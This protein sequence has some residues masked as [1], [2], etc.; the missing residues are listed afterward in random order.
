[1]APPMAHAGGTPVPPVKLLGTGTLSQ[2]S[3]TSRSSLFQGR[4]V[5]AELP[6]TRKIGSEQLESM[7]GRLYKPEK[8][9]AKTEAECRH[10]W[11]H[12][13][14]G[15]EAEEDPHLRGWWYR[16]QHGGRSPSPSRARTAPLRP[17]ALLPAPVSGSAVAASIL[18]THDAGEGSAGMSAAALGELVLSFADWAGLVACAGTSR[19][20]RHEACRV[21]RRQLQEQ[22]HAAAPK[23]RQVLR[24]A[25]RLAAAAGRGQR[26]RQDQLVTIGVSPKAPAASRSGGSRAGSQRGKP[27]PAVVRGDL[28]ALRV[29]I[30]PPLHFQAM[31]YRLRIDVASYDLRWVPSSTPEKLRSM[32]AAGQLR[33][34]NDLPVEPAEV[35]EWKERRDSRLE[36]YEQKKEQQ[37]QLKPVPMSPAQRR[38]LEVSRAGTGPSSLTLSGGPI[39]PVSPV[40]ER[41]PASEKGSP[42]Q[43]ALAVKTSGPVAPAARPDALITS[44]RSALC[45]LRAGVNPTELMPVDGQHFRK[46]AELEGHSR[47]IATHRQRHHERRRQD[48]LRG[49]QQAYEEVCATLS[50]EQ[51]VFLLQRYSPESNPTLAGLSDNVPVSDCDT[52]PPTGEECRKACE[53]LELRETARAC[54]DRSAGEDGTAPLAELIESA[55]LQLQM[56]PGLAGS[57]PARTVLDTALAMPGSA[58]RAV[59]WEELEAALGLDEESQV[60]GQTDIKLDNF[61]RRQQKQ[62]IDAQRRIEGHF[63]RNLKIGFDRQARAE[64]KRKLAEERKVV[65]EAEKERVALLRHE[66]AAKRA[67]TCAAALSATR[68]ATMRRQREL[69]ERLEADDQRQ[70]QLIERRERAAR[71]K[72]EDSR[73]A[74]QDKLEGIQRRARVDEWSKLRLVDRIR[75]KRD[76]AVCTEEALRKT[77]RTAGFAREQMLRDR[78]AVA[79]IIRDPP[80]SLAPLL[81]KMSQ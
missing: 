66:K 32:R 59:S 13:P 67:E 15:Y 38:S 26:Q 14:R 30:E 33:S 21:L 80:G 63:I 6:P 65:V 17:T 40:S 52:A 29:L 56:L 43:R 46:T 49:L 57:R 8:L 60:I 62:L 53:H 72:R 79:S 51:F 61:R 34:L 78:E 25:A 48:T 20:W 11:Q 37:L 12:R 28:T 50:L 76:R 47:R 35:I 22:G 42:S 74:V 31:V 19:G 27:T 36:R 3:S 58:S 24:V 7:L 45:L 68:E 44:P 18:K 73:L 64:E 2:E 71:L 4:P 23:G 39:S 16:Q 10:R 5:T 69:L 1:M 75:R 70:T 41:P 81:S 9:L 77:L 54:F 55:R